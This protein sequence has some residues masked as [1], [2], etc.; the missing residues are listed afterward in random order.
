MYY[1]HGDGSELTLW[2]ADSF[3]GYLAE[4]YSVEKV[5]EAYA[6]PERFAEIFGSTYA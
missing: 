6:V 5:L 3:V 2:Q 1:F 4:Q